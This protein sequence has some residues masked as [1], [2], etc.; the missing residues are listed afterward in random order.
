MACIKTIQ[1]TK[2]VLLTSLQW[3]FGLVVIFAPDRFVLAQLS[4][5]Y[6]ATFGLN[7]QKILHMCEFS[8]GPAH[9]GNGSFSQEVIGQWFGS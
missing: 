2:R 8:T 9:F 5:V 4:G 7:C 1:V 6:S 3:G